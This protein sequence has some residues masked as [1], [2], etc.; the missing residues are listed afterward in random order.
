MVFYLHLARRLFLFIITIFMV[1]S[2]LPTLFMRPLFFCGLKRPL[3]GDRSVCLTFDDGPNAKFTG[4][5][6]DLLKAY[7]VHATFFVV[8]ERARKNSALIQ[9][10]AQEGHQIGL[11]HYHHVSNWF[12][13]PAKTRKQC[14]LA[15]NA[16]EQI[17]GTRPIFYRPPWGHIN[18]FLPMV[19]GSYRIVLWSAILG[20]WHQ[21]LGCARLEQRIYRHLRPGAVIC[22]H[23][24]GE[25]LGADEDAPK[26]MI[27]ALSVVLKE[28]VDKYHFV[29]VDTLYRERASAGLNYRNLFH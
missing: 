3:P 6:L 15:A 28:S 17:T 16:V 10:M 11:H 20:D 24:D 26:N 13:S 21:K 5:L 1:Y 7:H 19:A 12:L 22:L 25:N 9:R 8:G 2:I 23:D 4:K 29:T 14:D 18:L 27:E